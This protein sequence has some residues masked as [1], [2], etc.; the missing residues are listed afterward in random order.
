MTEPDLNRQPV[1]HLIAEIATL[2]DDM[3]ALTAIVA[4]QDNTLTT[5]L[6][7]YRRNRPDYERARERRQA[8]RSLHEDRA[9]PLRGCSNRL[10]KRGW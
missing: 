10:S 3:R 7:A 6:T 5:L 9:F 8:T 2:H 4:R 1:E